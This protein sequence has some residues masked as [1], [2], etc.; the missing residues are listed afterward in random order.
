MFAPVVSARTGRV[1]EIEFIM[2]AAFSMKDTC[3]ILCCCCDCIVACRTRLVSPLTHHMHVTA[4]A[5]L[6]RCGRNGPMYQARLVVVAPAIS[7]SYVR[8]DDSLIGPACLNAPPVWRASSLLDWAAE[9]VRTA[10]Q[11][12]VCVCV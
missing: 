8:Q 1:C 6:H 3:R 12:C 10:I 11:V 7:A 2:H 4:Y 9:A 5:P